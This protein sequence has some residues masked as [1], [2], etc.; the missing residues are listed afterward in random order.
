V[1]GDII[2]ALDQSPIARVD[3]LHHLLTGLTAAKEVRLSVLR[4]GK[5]REF[6]VVL[7]EI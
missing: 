5:M 1:P 6:P 2:L 3:D 4:D 7:G